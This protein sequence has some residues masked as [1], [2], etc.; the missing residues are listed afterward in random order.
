[1]VSHPRQIPCFTIKKAIIIKLC[2]KIIILFQITCPITYFAL[3]S[4]IFQLKQT[5]LEILGS[6]DDDQTGRINMIVT[7]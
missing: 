4:V 6:C 1:M 3:F 5:R 7:V 2:K